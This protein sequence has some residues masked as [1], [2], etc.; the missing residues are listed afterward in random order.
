MTYALVGLLGLAVGFLAGIVWRD[1]LDLYLAS[2]KERR[3]MPTHNH[4]VNR[5]L[6]T[7]VLVVNSALGGFLI[8]QRAVAEEFTRCTSEWQSDFYDAYVPRSQAFADTLEALDGVV[9]S[10]AK[11]DQTEFDKAL[12]NYQ[13]IRRDQVADRKAT[14][15]PEL[16]A[17]ACGEGAK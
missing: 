10:V 15:L 16:P 6:L 9:S 2:R 13:E 17:T 5:W 8:Y 7:L 3:R 14:P 11:R 4:T 12:S 1:A